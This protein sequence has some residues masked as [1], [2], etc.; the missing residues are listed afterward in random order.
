[1][2]GASPAQM[3]NLSLWQRVHV[4]VKLRVAHGQ[5]RARVA[6]RAQTGL[7]LDRLR[8]L[9]HSQRRVLVP[10]NRKAGQDPVRLGRLA[11]RLGLGAAPRTFVLKASNGYK[12]G[13]RLHVQS[14]ALALAPRTFVLICLH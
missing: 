8:M 7:G 1:M 9:A 5:A 3:S 6:S 13:G 4:K 12:D 11:G 10:V 14:V 2:E